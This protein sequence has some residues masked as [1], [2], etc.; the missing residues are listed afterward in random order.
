MH[1]LALIAA[2]LATLSAC[3]PSSVGPGDQ[4]AVAAERQCFLPQTMRNFRSDGDTTVYVREGRGDVYQVTSSGCRGLSASRT[5]SLT[6][7]GG[8]SACVGDTVD[9]V[10]F[11]PSIRNENNST[12]Q[13]RILKRLTEDEVAALPSR[14][15]P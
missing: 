7:L 14:L 5:F 2:G 9:I 1:R 4:S 8:G 3:A 15:R 6:P 10:T 12:C 11:G 13:G